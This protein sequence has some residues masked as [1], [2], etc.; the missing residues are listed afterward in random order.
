MKLQD[1]KISRVPEMSL[2]KNFS[3][4]Q[5]LTCFKLRT[6]ETVSETTFIKIWN[7]VKLCEKQSF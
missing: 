6:T 1:I 3:E 4:K 2:I 7:E 5:L